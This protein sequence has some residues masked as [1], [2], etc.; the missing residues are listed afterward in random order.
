VR[1]DSFENR[2]RGI[3]QQGSKVSKGLR[4]PANNEEAETV[5]DE[6]S[7]DAV[8]RAYWGP[9]FTTVPLSFPYDPVEAPREDGDFTT[10]KQS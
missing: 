1:L 3:L 2:R 8:G 9:W 5:E 6:E 4:Q 7:E 10:R